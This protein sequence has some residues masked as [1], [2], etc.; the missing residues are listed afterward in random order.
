MTAAGAS[1]PRQTR[2][3]RARG[4]S[5][6][7][8]KAKRAQCRRVSNP[9][10]RCHPP[11]PRSGPARGTARG[12]GPACA[13]KP[14]G[15]G[16]ARRPAGAA[17]QAG[18]RAVQKALRGVL[19]CSGI[20]GTALA[21]AARRGARCGVSTICTLMLCSSRTFPPRCCLLL[22]AATQSAS[23]PRRR[24]EP[25]PRARAPPTSLQSGRA[26]STGATNI[27]RQIQFQ[28][29]KVVHALGYWT[30]PCARDR[31]ARRRLAAP[32]PSN[33]QHA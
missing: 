3:G 10:G 27:A 13:A 6:G 30:T 24:A 22:Q 25:G 19:D 17:S 4:R 9:A 16:A 15:N 12:T 26:I 7:A 2:G 20:R 5:A 28:S 33:M 31:S 21:S 14:G 23:R 18:R 11:G 8:G 29:G 1:S 32:R